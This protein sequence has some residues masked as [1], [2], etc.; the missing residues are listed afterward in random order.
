[1]ASMRDLDRRSAALSV[2]GVHKVYGDGAEALRGLSLR[3]PV[4]A[5]FG[6]LG[7]N[8]SGKSTL[9]GMVSGLVRAPAGH[10]FVLGH[11]AVTDAQRARLLLGVAPQE[12]HW[13]AS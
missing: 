8:G 12:V 1:M 11:D 2:E 6:L 9:I 4:G 10:L 7:P 3:I 5:F 13:T